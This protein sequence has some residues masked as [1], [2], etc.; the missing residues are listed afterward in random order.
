[1]TLTGGGDVTLLG[2]DYGL[3]SYI[4]AYIPTSSAYTLTANVASVIG[5]NAAAP[6][7]L[8]SANQ[9]SLTSSGGQIGTFKYTSSVISPLL[10]NISF[11]IS[12]NFA[13]STGSITFRIQKNGTN[14][15]TNGPN[16]TAVS[17]SSQTITISTVTSLATNDYIGL[18]ATCT[19]TV[20][21]TIRGTNTVISAL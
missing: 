7:T 17:T 8:I 9:F 12:Y 19:N 2:T 1:M 6:Y 3:K 4:A 18:I 5:S 10:V 15:T 20:S 16:V 14:L 11:N 13:S 21:F